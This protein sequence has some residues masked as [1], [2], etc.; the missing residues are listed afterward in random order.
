MQRH[1]LAVTERRCRRAIVVRKDLFESCELA[2][3][4]VEALRAH[5]AVLG[6]VQN[7]PL[8]D[9]WIFPAP[10]DPSK[11][12]PRET[13]HQ[14]WKRLAGAAKLPVGQ[15]YGWHA[16][17]RAFPNWLPRCGAPFRDLQD[18]GDW[19]SPKTLTEVYLLPDEEARSGGRSRRRSLNNPD[20]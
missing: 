4:V 1:Q 13:A 19:K 20:G 16:F 9:E 6:L 7:C 11:P 8:S 10:E 17:H 15:R 5:K 12:M 3:K 14:L 2:Y 18:L